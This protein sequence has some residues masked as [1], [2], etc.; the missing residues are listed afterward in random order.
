[1]LCSLN[2]IEHM[3]NK[4][5]EKKP[6]LLIHQPIQET[7]ILRVSEI[8]VEMISIAQTPLLS[9]PIFNPLNHFAQHL[10]RGRLPSSTR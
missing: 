10:D 1:M 6:S 4:Q 3:Q 5:I 2:P 8:H 9:E 7:L